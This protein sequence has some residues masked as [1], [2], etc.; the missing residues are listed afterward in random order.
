[1]WANR[2][3]EIC[4]KGRK[5]ILLFYFQDFLNTSLNLF[6]GIQHRTS[7]PVLLQVI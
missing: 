2:M 1:M 6:E 4:P 3:A 5:L 7:R